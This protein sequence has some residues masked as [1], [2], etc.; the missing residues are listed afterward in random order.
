MPPCSAW[1]VRADPFAV[2]PG[3]ST[4]GSLCFEVL[5]PMLPFGR[6]DVGASSS[7]SMVPETSGADDAIGYG[8]TCVEQVYTGKIQSQKVWTFPLES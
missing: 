2:V 7:A 4:T 3:T 5:E 8:L 6:D 1:P